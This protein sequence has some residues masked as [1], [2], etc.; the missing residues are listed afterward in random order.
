MLV[1]DFMIVSWFRKNFLHLKQYLENQYTDLR[2]R[3]DGANYPPSWY[4][5]LA[6]SC[7]SSLQAVF[8][9][10]TF[11]GPF[12]LNALGF[13]QLPPL[14]VQVQENRMLIFVW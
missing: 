12:I 6:I 9:L 11:L 10:F 7:M 4:A 5:A 13:N 2:G 14:F 1:P 8:L 3:I